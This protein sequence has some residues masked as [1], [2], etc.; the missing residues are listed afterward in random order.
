L[1]FLFV[2]LDFSKGL[3]AKFFSNQGSFSEAYFECGTA[4]NLHV[5]K[6]ERFGNAFLTHVQAD[7]FI[8]TLKLFSHLG[9]NPFEGNT[10]LENSFIKWLFALRKVNEMQEDIVALKLFL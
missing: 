8:T 1:L 9:F 3:L 10:L 7:V 5:N 4:L 6:T 2:P